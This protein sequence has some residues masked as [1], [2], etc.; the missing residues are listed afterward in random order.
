L[1][2]ALVFIS[3]RV[4][5]HF[6]GLSAES[7]ALPSADPICVFLPLG[8]AASAALDAP[9]DFSCAAVDPNSSCRQVP[10]RLRGRR[11]CC[12]PVSLPLSLD[13][14]VWLESLLSAFGFPVPMK[15]LYASVL[16]SSGFGF[17][18]CCRLKPVTSFAL[19]K[20]Y[21]SK[22]IFPIVCELLQVEAGL[23]LSHRNKRLEVLC[24]IC[25]PAVIS[26]TR[27]PVVR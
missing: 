7:L 11:S 17:V 16:Y 1:W 21:S 4:P 8:F 5:I 24:L 26:Q 10:V 2:P 3:R 15:K 19:I 23:L 22:S 20:C 9:V 14:D 18:L 25:T 13:L 6:F 27:T 12:T